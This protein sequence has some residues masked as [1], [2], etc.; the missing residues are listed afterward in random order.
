MYLCLPKVHGRLNSHPWNEDN[1]VESQ[2][3]AYSS[4]GF[5]HVHVSR[6]SCG[7]RT[8]ISPKINHPYTN[9]PTHRRNSG[10]IVRQWQKR[11]VCW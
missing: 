3:I 10:T 6:N 1:D 4:R 2:R 9:G 11:G 8:D 5:T 7:A